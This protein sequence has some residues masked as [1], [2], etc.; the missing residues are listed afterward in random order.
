[1][2]AYAPHLYT[3]ARHEIALRVAREEDVDRFMSS[4]EKAGLP[5]GE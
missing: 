3:N 4:L 2:R 1:V 5:P